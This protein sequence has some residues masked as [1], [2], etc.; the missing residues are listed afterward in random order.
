MPLMA[1]VWL[2]PK[3][4]LQL[5]LFQQSAQSSDTLVF[6][7]V[8]PISTPRTNLDGLSNSV[9]NKPSVFKKNNYFYDLTVFC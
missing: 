2:V 7:L 4:V 1:K 6:A 3:Q 8:Q 9:R 5:G